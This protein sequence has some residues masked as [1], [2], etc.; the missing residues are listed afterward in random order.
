MA[1]AKLRFTI[2]GFSL[3]PATVIGGSLGL[4]AIAI[5]SR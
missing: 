3:I 4:T 5:R 2:L 1:Q